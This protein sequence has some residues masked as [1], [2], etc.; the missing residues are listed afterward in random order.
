MSANYMQ[1]HWEGGMLAQEVIRRAEEGRAAEMDAQRL[2]RQLVPPSADISLQ[3]RVEGACQALLDALQRSKDEQKSLQKEIDRAEI[4]L[5]D[6]ET[7]ARHYFERKRW[8]P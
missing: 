1:F 4:A 2:A 3:G 8:T 5:E 7:T 6:I